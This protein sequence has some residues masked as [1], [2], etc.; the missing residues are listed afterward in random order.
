MEALKSGYED[1]GRYFHTILGVPCLKS[2]VESLESH[3]IIAQHNAPSHCEACANAGNL[4]EAER[5]W[6][7]MQREGIHPN[8][9]LG[10]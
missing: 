6:E 9:R 3:L 7:M 5:L 10:F 2:P 4:P 8:Q 1:P